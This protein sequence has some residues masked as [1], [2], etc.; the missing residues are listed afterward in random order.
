MS[1]TTAD[2]TPQP[3]GKIVAVFVGCATTVIGGLRGVGP[4][5]LLTRVLV[6]S[7]ISG[8]I[9]GAFMTVLSL[10]QPKDKDD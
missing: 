8:L 4:S 10:S 6:G 3:W 7:T 2:R 5:E 9:V 1:D